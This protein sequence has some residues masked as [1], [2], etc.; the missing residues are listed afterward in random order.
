MQYDLNDPIKIKEKLADN[1]NINSKGRA[2]ILLIKFPSLN[3]SSLTKYFSIN[4]TIAYY[5]STI[6][7]Y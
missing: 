2:L 6:K 5:I 4:L 7:R 1:S 3:N